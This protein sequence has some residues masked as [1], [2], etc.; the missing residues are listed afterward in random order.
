MSKII[1]LIKNIIKRDTEVVEAT[2]YE[3]EY[4]HPIEGFDEFHDNLKTWR[5][6]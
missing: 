2:P 3:F 1:N 5:K 4:G 6:R